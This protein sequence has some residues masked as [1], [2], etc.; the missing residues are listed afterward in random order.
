MAFERPDHGKHRTTYEKNKKKILATQDYCAIC[1]KLVDK[2]IPYKNNKGEFNVWSATV[3]HII[4]ISKGGHPSDLDNLQL[5]HFKC[6][7]QKSD[8]L[9]GINPNTQHQEQVSNRILPLTMDWK[10]YKAK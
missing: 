6:N 3:D 1:G 4:P 7:R 9:V 8:K 2:T 5:T 10:S